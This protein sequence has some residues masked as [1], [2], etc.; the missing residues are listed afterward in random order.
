[1]NWFGLSEHFVVTFAWLLRP[2]MLNVLVC[3]G[4]LA[5]GRYHGD[6]AGHE[7]SE[8]LASWAQRRWLGVS[9]SFP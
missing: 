4:P 2:W 1:M 9:C 7:E 3:T 5:N 8:A 6:W